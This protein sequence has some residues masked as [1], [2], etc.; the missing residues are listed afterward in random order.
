VT[1]PLRHAD[2][3][4]SDEQRSLRDTFARL[5]S[6]EC[7]TERVRAA[8]PLGFDRPLWQRLLE[9][10]IVSMG[11]PTESGGDG[12]GLV[13]LA[14]VAE[15]IGRRLAPVPFIEAAVSARLLARCGPGGSE[16]LSAAMAGDELVTLALQP[17]AAG[18]AQ[19]IPAAAVADAVI[20]NLEDELIIARPD[21]PPR[22]APNHGCTPLGSFDLA[23]ASMSAHLGPVGADAAT[24]FEQ[25]GREWKLLTAAAQVGI[26]E[27]A[28][29]LAVDYARERT[30]FGVPIAAFQG[31]SHPLVD[32][33][34]AVVGARRLVWKAAWFADHEP[35]AELQLI[36][37]AFA[38]ACRTSTKAATVGVHTLGGFG[39]T[40]ESDLQLF[41][42]RAKGWANIAGDPATELTI[43][44]D[45]LYGSAA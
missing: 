33:H 23:R 36:P 35:H 20:G 37:M 12:A 1:V 8:E 4:L 45:T 14:L 29:A 28:L 43:I 15:A 17:S 3:S 2:F 44:A 25:A 24:L 26:A 30:A 42:R 27:G 5:L 34:I 7:P 38:H 18:T 32:C 31:V 19:L 22:H 9:Q 16:W 11:V 41:F 10:Q 13:E 39:V 40:L 6:R 21:Q